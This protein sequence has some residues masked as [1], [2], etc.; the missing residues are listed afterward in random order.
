MRWASTS[1]W[2]ATRWAGTM[3]TSS[4]TGCMEGAADWSA[5]ASVSLLQGVGKNKIADR[6]LQLLNLPREYLQLHRCAQPLSAHGPS[7]PTPTPCVHCITNLTFCPLYCTVYSQLIW[8]GDTTPSFTL[9]SL[10]STS[11]R[12]YMCVL[13]YLPTGILRC[14]R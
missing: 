2:W 1:C 6:F 9:V 13:H 14:R 7:P 11:G 3:C 5:S 8:R 10:L 12:T 4:S